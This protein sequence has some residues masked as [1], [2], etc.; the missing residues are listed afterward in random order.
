[1]T[2][3]AG[4]GAAFVDASKP[5]VYDHLDFLCRILLEGAQ[6]GGNLSIVEERGALGCMTPRHVHAREAETFVVLEG[7]LEGWCEGRTQLVEAGSVI[8]LPAGREHAFRVVSTDAHFYTL[9]TPA[10]FESFFA[11]TGRLVDQAFT[12]DLPVP[13]PVLP[14]VA[15]G[16][17][18]ALEPLGCAIT[19]PPPFEVT[20]P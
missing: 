17:R 13:G 2:T 10:G 15:E 12:G 11:A 18:R 3:L 4:S 5:A 7:A 1:M 19:G 9:I 8:H 14:D 6:S 16:L 20:A